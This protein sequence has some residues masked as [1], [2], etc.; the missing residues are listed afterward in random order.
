MSSTPPASPGAGSR[1]AS[2]PPR[3]TRPRWRR[4]VTPASRRARSSR[5]SSRAPASRARCRTPA[6]RGSATPS[7]PVGEALGGTG[8]YGL[9]GRLHPPPRAV[10]VLRIDGQPAPPDDSDRQPAGR[11]AG[12]PARRSARDTQSYVNGVPQFNTP[13]HNYDTS[14]FDQLVAAINSDQLPSSA[15]PAVSFLKAPGYEDGHAGYSDPADEQQFIVHT[16]NEIMRTPRLE[17]H[18][19]HHQLRRLRRLVRPRLQRRHQPVAVAGRQPHQHD[20][21]RGDVRPVRSQ[22]ADRCAAGWRAGPLRPRP[23]AA[24]DGDLAVRSAQRT[25]TTT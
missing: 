17:A 4:P 16:I 21:Q 9:Q 14:D 5:T 24:D 18:R 12:R 15:L 11:H 2:G 22:A 19:D 20:A 23:A 13:N 8:Q 3:P 10:P 6:T 25:S 1:A 7:H